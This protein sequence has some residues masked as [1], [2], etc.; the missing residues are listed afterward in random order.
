MFVA[1]SEDLVIPLEIGKRKL[2]Q[3]PEQFKKA[4]TLFQLEKVLKKRLGESDISMG[5]LEQLIGQNSIL[6]LFMAFLWGL[7]ASLTPCVYPM[8]PITVST[9][10]IRRREFFKGSQIY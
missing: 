7:L 2:S 4:Q 8:I 6:A 10:F 5:Q 1:E 3:T 9:I